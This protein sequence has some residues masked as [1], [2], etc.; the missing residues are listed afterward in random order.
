MCGTLVFGGGETNE[1]HRRA[2]RLTTRQTHNP[3]N[4]RHARPQPVEREPTPS[5]C[6][7]F[8]FTI[9]VVNEQGPIVVVAQPATPSVRPRRRPCLVH[10]VEESEWPSVSCHCKNSG[11]CCAVDQRPDQALSLSLDRPAAGSEYRAKRLLRTRARADEP[12]W[13]QAAISIF[14]D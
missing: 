3:P 1:T 10:W 6:L 9:R 13:C 12:F 7:R 4:T 2:R 8:R 11:L 14:F 5:A